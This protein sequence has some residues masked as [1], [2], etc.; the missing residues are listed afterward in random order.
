MLHDRAV[1]G[2]KIMKYKNFCIARH[3]IHESSPQ[4]STAKLRPWII[5][6]GISF[7][8]RYVNAKWVINKLIISSNQ[9]PCQICLIFG[10]FLFAVWQGGFLMK[11][12]PENKNQMHY[13]K[14][15]FFVIITRINSNQQ[16]KSCLLVF[17]INRAVC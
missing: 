10:L 11:H 9:R 3:K 16:K 4:I 5:D 7:N 12:Q 1:I 8:L 2:Q 13:L 6:T 15:N 14:Q 17:L